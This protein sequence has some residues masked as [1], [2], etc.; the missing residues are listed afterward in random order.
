MI[1]VLPFCAKDAGLAADNLRWMAEL[2]SNL[3]Y[4]CLLS[5]DTDTPA[6]SVKEIQELAGR[7]FPKVSTMWYPAPD[8]KY[9]PAAPNWAFQSAAN[10]V[11]HFYPKESWLFLE[12]DAT[13]I[14]AGW[15]QAIE[16]E[17]IKG[18]KAFTGHVVDGM[19]HPNGVA[20]YPPMV[21]AYSPQ[22][23][24]VQDTAWDV[25]IG[26]TVDKEHIHNAGI[27]EY[28]GKPSVHLI[29]HCWNMHEETGLPT[30][31]HGYSPTF[32]SVDDVIR[33]VDLNAA[34]YHR[35]KDGSLIKWLREFYK[36]PTAA[37]V[38]N[39]TGHEERH[40]NTDGDH[41]SV[42]VGD[43]CADSGTLLSVKNEQSVAEPDKQD[44]SGKC[45]IFIVTYSK[46][47]PWL[48]WCL[49]A[50]RKHCTGFQGV[51]LAIP[52]RDAE[53]FRVIANEH[54]QSNSGIKLS[55]RLF[56]EKPGKGMLAHMAVMGSADELVPPGTTHVL[57]LDADCIFKEPVTPSEYIHGDRPVYVWRTYESL[58]EMREGQKVV[59]DCLQWKK[60]TEDQ[61]GFPVNQYCMTRHPTVF[62]VSFYKPYREHIEKV[63][64]KPYME[65][66]TSG[67]NEFPQNRMDFTAMGG[68]AA[69]FMPDSFYWIDIS[70]GNH[71]APKDKQKTY[72]SHGGV[73]PAVQ[74]EIESF[75]K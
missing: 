23:M 54:A 41:E 3:P 51:T 46:D 64:G 50:I 60:P 12:A 35:C 65:Y 38:P 49:R 14:R 25:V 17:H 68:W 55:V 31:G 52:D 75:L 7:L 63:H 18:G 69:K 61:L 42:L 72:W 20:V 40:D 59:S 19:G 16:A 27:G 30:N 11:A 58:S 2:D 29:Q 28:N 8:K 45:E 43:G 9:W 73:T 44:F 5:H 47:A 74:Q 53:P 37:M 39:H 10:Y 6:A 26:A 67:R 33:K 71:L 32:K 48:T 62:P 56:K 13:P 24:Q 70:G 21:S 22:A 36:N 34:I 15:L 57:H 66:M 4:E 1:L